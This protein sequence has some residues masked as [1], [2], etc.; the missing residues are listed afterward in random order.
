MLRLMA[1]APLSLLYAFFGG[2][3][4][5]LRVTG[6]RRELVAEG[7]ARCL[8]AETEASRRRTLREFYVA[9]GRLAAEFAH[10]ARI[11]PAAL[12]A[13]LRF[14][15]PD[16]VQE[17]LRSG[18]R[19]LLLAG[20]HC[21]WEWLLLRCSG[22]FGVPLVAAY[23]PA[24]WARAD[25]DILAMRTRFGATMIPASDLVPH[26]IAQRGEVRLLAMLAD[27]SP[28]AVSE[29]QSWLPFF[30]VDTAF[31]R[32]PGW[33]CARMG[34]VPFFIALR[35]EGRGRY[36]ARFV[37]LAGAGARPDAEQLLGA[38]VRALEQQV[39]AHPA[40]YFWA[41]NRWKRP[42]RLYD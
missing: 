16:L 34:F 24:S 5:L 26:L 18:Q 41:Y 28:P 12:V 32:G 42:R 8:G 21:N 30:G 7:L 9:L 35:P 15:N 39:A 19:V 36:A 25:R 6:W 2:V 38:Y 31:Y 10:A 1:L 20:H 14:E 37:P 29:V 13:R 3:A 17:R 4:W 33:L 27:Q 11:R 22:A 23:K 40:H